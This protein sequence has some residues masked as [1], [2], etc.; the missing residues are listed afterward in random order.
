MREV[1]LAAKV[2][3]RSAFYKYQFFR[4]YNFKEETYMHRC[5]VGP[6]IYHIAKQCF[7]LCKIYIAHID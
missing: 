4:T 6:H 1:L 7:E 2:R 5:M 3:S